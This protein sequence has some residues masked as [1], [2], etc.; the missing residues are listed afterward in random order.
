M[1]HPN[2]I[3]LP[4]A[5]GRWI[6]QSYW[7]PDAVAVTLIRHF[8]AK[9]GM[10][11]TNSL[12]PQDGRMTLVH[13]DREFDLR[14]SVLPASHG[15]R[16]VIRFLEQGRVRRLSGAGFSLAA[17]QTLRRA[18]RRRRGS[19]PKNFETKSRRD[20]RRGGPRC[21]CRAGLRA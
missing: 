10:D 12:I 15:E 7:L 1:S 2:Q 6:D 9:C 19:S 16:L 14:V 13:Q 3:A 4:V 17:L 18:I 11:S 20:G 5:V 21:C 8:K